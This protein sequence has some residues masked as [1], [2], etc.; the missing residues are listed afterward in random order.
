[1]KEDGPCPLLIQKLSLNNS[2]EELPF[3]DDCENM[4]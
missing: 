4:T 2:K 3:S 1:M